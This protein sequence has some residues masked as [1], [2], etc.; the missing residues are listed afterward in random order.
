[1]VSLGF[2]SVESENLRLYTQISLVSAFSVGWLILAAT[3]T[4]HQAVGY[5][6]GVLTIIGASQY[7]LFREFDAL[8]YS[9]ALGGSLLFGW[10]YFIMRSWVLA[11]AALLILGVG[12]TEWVILA[13]DS[14]TASLIGMFVV[15]ALVALIGASAISDEKTL[16]GRTREA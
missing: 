13:M 8:S 12:L 7:A 11:T 6:L 14:S 5:A 10:L 3:R 9:I 16:A 15:G 2:Q 1:M 4:V